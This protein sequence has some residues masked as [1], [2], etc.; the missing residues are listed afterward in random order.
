MKPLR[1]FLDEKTPLLFDGAMGTEIYRRGVYVNRC[2][3]EANLG[4]SGIILDIHRD[5]RTAGAEVLSTNSWGAGLYKLRAHGLG[6][7]LREINVEAARLA[8]S[9]A[10][11]ELYVAGSIG[12]L[13]S[14]MAPWGP[15]GREEVFGAFVEQLSALRDG[16]VD[17]FLFETFVDAE[18]L[19]VALAAARSLGSGLPVF[20]CLSTDLEGKLLYGPSLEAAV[21]S[22]VEGGADVVGLNCRVGPSPM[23]NTVRKL[24]GVAGRPLL[25]QPN[26]GLPSEVEGRTIYM[27]TPEYFAQYTKYFL[28]EGVRFVGGCC[29]TTPA[30]TSAMA[31][32]FRHY[33]AMGLGDGS[34]VA[35]T[36]RPGAP[37]VVAT[38]GPEEAPRVPFAEK[39]RWSAKL[40]RG[41][42]VFS[43]ELVP[44]AGITATKLLENAKRIRD[45]GVDAIN[46]PDGPRASSRM[47]AIITAILV[48]QKVGIETI[49]HYTCRDRNLIG[50]QSDMLGAQAIGLRNVLL[51]TG[52]PPKL[53]EYP[54]AT[55][56]FD[57]D[58]VGLARMVRRLN[59]GIDVG[60]RSIGEPTAISMGVGVNPVH[61]DFDYEMR[62]FAKKIEA[63]AEWAITQPVFDRGALERFLAHLEREGIR[64]PLIVGIW[65]LTSLK[66]AQF[67]ANEVPGIVIPET[68]LARMA[69]AEGPETARDT[70]VEIARELCLGLLDEVAGVQISAP[71]GRVDLALRVI[72]KE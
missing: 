21:A 62:R 38:G 10:K 64:I 50:M 63:G 67:M 42:K 53:G 52:D 57:V 31:R 35:D 8:R 69:R 26:A 12:P 66:N 45:A 9:V 32:A 39:S 16:G 24:K 23:L 61:R 17:L 14:R 54:D 40:A 2:F 59:G 56:V 6:D 3:E 5:Y 55:G 29:G 28:Q 4:N 1:R 51:I 11:D 25:V 18:E 20:A 7:R 49:L 60:G 13:G 19:G 22:L 36:E 30:H 58:A 71:F 41:E 48:E 47:S 46:I 33:K 15:L 34:I 27:T 65:P 68:T 44:P 37:R 72:G 43:I 70:G